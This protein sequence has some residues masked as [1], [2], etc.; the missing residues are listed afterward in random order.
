MSGQLP[1]TWAAT[2]DDFIAA[3]AA[4]GE[5]VA[6]RK[7]SQQAI[8]AFAAALPELL[9]G[10]A[11]LTGSVFTNWSGSMP[12]T[13][14]RQ[15]QLHPF[16]RPRIRDERD[17]Q[18]RRAAR[19][20]HPV[21]RH[22]PHLLR[23]RAQR[24]ADVGADEAAQHLRLHARLDRPRRGRSDAPIGRACG[25]PAP[26]S[27][28]RCLA[29]L[30][31]RRDGGGLG[32]GHR[33]RATA[34]ARSCSRGRT[35]RSSSATR[36]RL[37]RSAPAAT[38]SPT[39]RSRPASG[40]VIIATGSEVAL[41]M[42]ARDALAAEG[43]AVRVVSMPCTRAFDRQDAG[44]RASVLPPG[45]PARCGRGRFDRWLAQVRR[46]GR[47]PAGRGHRSRYVRRVGAR[48]R[49]VQ[50]LRHHGRGRRGGGTAR[51]GVTTLHSGSG[52]L[53]EAAIDASGPFF[54]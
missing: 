35:C 2:V 17:R 46:R 31:Q 49:A 34:R 24:G 32:R 40:A 38:C 6:T 8:E 42:S 26:H 10:S 16:R 39:G 23:L 14:D 50:A 19:R 4:K 51:G 47:R 29:A 48:W 37:P 54:A 3:Q 27:E 11:D 30:R 13:R 53:P 5:S 9:G 12:V 28:S 1:A 22:V 25:E 41:A 15:W 7:A 33:A 21:R 43:I 45:V 36:S 18:R 44:Y 20:A 52:V